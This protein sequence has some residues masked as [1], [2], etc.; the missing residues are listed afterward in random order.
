MS[1]LIG[2]GPILCPYKQ[3]SYPLR[4]H[5]VVSIQKLLSG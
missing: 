2:L 5:I 4:R 3:G 1:T